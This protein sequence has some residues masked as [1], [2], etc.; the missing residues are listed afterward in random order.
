MLF[1]YQNCAVEFMNSNVIQTTNKN[2]QSGKNSLTQERATK[3][4]AIDIPSISLPKGGGALKGIDEKFEVNS[5]NG[6]A[7]LTIP[8]PVTPGRNGITPSLS[9]HYNS[10][11]GNGAF[12]LGWSLGLSSIQRQTD[13]KLPRYREGVDGDTYMFS[14]AEDLVPYLE[15][16][17]ITGDWTPKVTVLNGFTIQAYRP[18]IEGNFTRI[19]K[20]SNSTLGTYWKV[21]S[22]DNVATFYGKSSSCR[23]ADP[24]DSSR[25]LEWLPEFSY[26]D[27]GN[28]IHYHYKQDT[29]ILI[30]DGEQTT[31]IPDHVY[32]RNRKAG[33]APFTNTY[34]KKVVYGNHQPYYADAA[35]RYNP[36]LP[37]DPQYFF[38]VVFDYGEHDL[39][40]P[41]P[42]DV[43]EWTYRADAFSSYRAGFEIRTSRL[44]R[45]VLMFH[46][47]PQETQFTGTPDEENFG[48]NYLV[49]SL[50]LTYAPSSINNSGQAEVTYLINATQKGYI[51]KPDGSY[52]EKAG[53]PMEFSYQNLHWNTNLKTVSAENIF[54]APAGLTTNYHWVDL[55]GEGICGILSEQ[56]TGWFYKS[57]LGDIDGNGKVTFTVAKNILARPSFSGLSTGSLSLQDLEGNGKKQI[58]VTTDSVKGYFELRND[59]QV[60]P[61]H[62]FA[63]NINTDTQNRNIRMLDLTGDGKPDVVITEEQVFIWYASEGK[64]GYAP[65]EKTLQAL[66]EERGP[67]VIFSDQ[68]Q[69][70]FLADMSGDGLTDIV[71]VRNGELCYWA[72]MG[73]GKFSAKITMANAPR[74]DFPELFNAKYLHL[75]DISGTGATDILYLGNNTFKAYI[76]LSGNAWSDAHEIEPFLL[77]DHHTKLSV[78]DLLGTGTSCIVWSSGLPAYKEAPMRYIDLMD[79]K[80]PHIMTGYKNNL[81]K[82]ISFDYKSSTHYYLKD[83]LAGTPWVTRLPFPVHVVSKMTMEEKITNIKFSSVYTYHHGYYDP[84]EKE[85]RGFGS[86]EQLDSEFYDHWK[87][88]NDT[89]Q[90]E[91]DEAVFQK[92][93]L[94]KSWFHTGA[95]FDIEKSLIQFKKEY[96]FA[97]YDQKFPLSPLTISEIALTDAQLTQDVEALQGDEFREAL[98]AC[99]GMM[100]RQE[101]FALDAEEGDLDSLKKQA[102]PYTVSQNNCQ[103]HLIQPRC[104]NVHAVFMVTPAESLSIHYERNETD[105]RT[106]HTLVT[107]VNELGQVVESASIVYPRKQTA[108]NLPAE[109]R[110]KQ[111]QTHIV[112]SRHQYTNDIRTAEAYRLRKVAASETFEIIGLPSSQTYFQV[113]DFENILAGGS[114]EVQYHE[115]ST[116]GNTQRRLIESINVLYNRDDLSGPLPFGVMESKGINH[117]S[118]QLAYT[119]ELLADIFGNKLPAN[120]Q[121]LENLMGDNDTDGISSQGKFVHRNDNNWWI[122]SGTVQF[123]QPQETLA[124]IENRFYLPIA[125]TN[126]FGT[127]TT[128]SYWKDYFLFIEKT[129]DALGNQVAVERINFRTLSPSRMRDINDNVSEVMLDERGLVKALAIMGKGDEADDLQGLSE[130][131][132]DAEE[133]LIKT[134]F[135]RS[136]TITLR[137]SARQLLQHA[138]GRFVYDFSRYQTSVMLLA[139]QLQDNPDTQPCAL[140]KRLPIVVGSI[141]REQHYADNPNSSLQLRFEYTDGAGNVAMVKSQSDGGEA[142][143]LTIQ[144]DCNYTVQSIDTSATNQLRWIGNGRTILNNKGNPVKQYEPYFATTPFFED[145]KELVERGVTP[146]LYYDPAGRLIRTELPNGTF[147][148]VEFDAWQQR[149]FDANDTVLES[150][151]FIDQGSPDPAGLPPASSG[152]LSAWK[153]AQHSNTPTLIHLDTLGRSVFSVVHNRTDDVDEFYT[154][155]VHLDIEGNTRS[156]VDHRGNIVTAYK[157]DLLGHRVYQRSNESGERWILNNLAGN[158]LRAWDGRSHT[159]STRYDVL[160]RPVETHVQGG[161]DEI[162]LDHVFGKT[163]YGE[164][165]INDTV[166]NLRGKPVIIYDTAGKIENIRFDFKGN[167]LEATRQLATDYKQTPH[168]SAPNPDALL[169]TEIFTSSSTYDALN[170]IATVTTP[171]GSVSMATYNASGLLGQLQVQP[172]A[173]GNATA[174]PVLFVRAV[175]YNERGQRTTILYGNNVQTTYTYDPKTFRLTQLVSQKQNN[176]LLQNL[177]YTYDPVGNITTLEDRAIA[178]VFFGNHQIEPKSQYTYDAAYRLVQAIGREHIAQV[179]LG[180]NDNWNDLPFLKQ[181]ST[182]DPMAWRMYT[183]SYRYDSAGNIL[184]MQHQAS[185][186]SWTRDYEY[187]T[188]SNRLVNTVVADETYTYPH[189]QQHGFITGMPHLSVM[190]WNFKDELRATARQVINNGI[191]ETTYYVYNGAGQRVRKVTENEGGIIK[192]DERIYLGG[193]EIYRKHSGT[194]TGLE[195]ITLHVADDSDRIAMVDTRNEVN[196]NT[197]QRTIRY[198]LNNRIGSAALELTGNANPDVINY[199]E[200]H[201]Y[202]STSY[203]A[204]N[205]AIRAAAKRYRYTGMERDEETGLNYHTARYYIPWLARWLSADPIGIGDGLNVYAYVRQSPV[206]MFDSSGHGSE[207]DYVVPAISEYLR[208]SKISHATEVTFVTI[209]DNGD[210]VHGRFD[211]VFR[212]PRNGQLVAIEL[213]G[214][215]VDKLHG[216]QPTYVPILES[217]AGGKI[218]FTSNKVEAIGLNKD[219]TITVNQDH[220]FRMGVHSVKDFGDALTQITGG[221]TILHRYINATTREAKFFTSTAE[222]EKFLKARFNVN[223]KGESLRK[224]EDTTKKE[225]ST[226]DEEHRYRFPDHNAPKREDP[227]N[228]P[229]KNNNNEEKKRFQEQEN[230]VTEQ[231]AEEEAQAEEE[232][233][234]E[235]KRRLL[236]DALEFKPQPAPTAGDWVIL[237]GLGLVTAAAVASPF[238]GPAGDVAAGSLTLGQ[239]AR[240]GLMVR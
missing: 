213:K 139:D 152:P 195:R 137:N 197:D 150:Q 48:T 23:T 110:Q 88:A 7:G 93:V 36:L 218:R 186:G 103:I 222:F 50:D 215:N 154:T 64:R 151:W 228:D 105:P 124:D 134:Y 95:F 99:K 89:T 133:E 175:N 168:W 178:T 8:L 66:D 193:I 113:R 12:G 65:S 145:V 121:D 111:A 240:M 155:T 3:S 55:Y 69:C 221:K 173:T 144:P 52:S 54:H 79:S 13:K 51:R 184:Q 135:T 115:N 219:D 131:T 166:N 9:L 202:G 102:K 5:A 239:A 75:A 94:I 217:E 76:N 208:K 236:R 126:P 149:S 58:V 167:L 82:E 32:E 15:K 211:V 142:L 125:Y 38:E 118:Y 200:Y 6:T 122:R 17:S 199:E 205:A 206:N 230:N 4:N 146:I 161:D 81:G 198:Q 226:K 44:C 238:E 177:I 232:A 22:R 216:N 85:F 207:T 28:W 143:Q 229:P 227:P 96:W 130:I 114:S 194:N 181:Y 182:S 147:T 72:N 47:F 170:R 63:G 59:E 234:E 40:I 107:Q 190:R 53:P 2:E 140:V 91:K 30:G 43:N 11:S 233:L 37:A 71:R 174:D 77:I 41:T 188:D 1:Y 164:G 86:V 109:I 73:Y 212:D 83:K 136:D 191:P 214:D 29:H 176:E 189:H 26:D 31:T 192:K 16:N 179:T 33:L 35:D 138:T 171:D 18:R 62:A 106:A 61:F 180:N 120:P 74:F 84:N 117:E 160:Q 237:I 116:P 67:A 104:N 231:T 119:P 172:T 20:I 163:Q 158:L 132:T 39:L 70:I 209:D 159:F 187:Q 108:L 210:E 10:G 19:E 21:T 92:P 220:Y 97:Q 169:E 203:Q 196:D 60:E 101:V 141:V 34:L 78:I 157:Y 123:K 49:S 153:T 68:E 42:D 90:L 225:D 162:P 27:K 165:L 127:V 129:T 25:I 148:T 185:G 24:E 46:H 56:G 112:Y 98:R 156:I 224:K 204:V 235:K 80:K 183:Q 57:N 223:L 87:K 201:P 100:L 45:R 14:G 128:V